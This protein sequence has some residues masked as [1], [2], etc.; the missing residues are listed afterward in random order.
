MKKVGVIGSGSVGQ[1]LASGFLKHGYEVMLG[2][3]D[4][5]KLS[6]WKSKNT[7]GQMGT[8]AETAK[9]GEIIV[10]CPKG[11][12]AEDVLRNAGIENFSGKTINDVTNPIDNK[13]PENGVIKYFTSKDES[14]MERLQNLAPKANFVKAFNSVGNAFMVNPDFHG[15]K[16]TMFI[17][18]NNEIARKEVTVIVEKFGHEVEDLGMSNA[19][20]VIEQLC[21]LWCIPGMLRNQWTHAFKLL[22]M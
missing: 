14:L 20:S 8:F 22:K 6:D 17:C 4:T 18:G 3:R 9:F 7:K 13:P 19:A 16:P 1:V 2:S 21:I 5:S 11:T 10:F 15:V 12:A